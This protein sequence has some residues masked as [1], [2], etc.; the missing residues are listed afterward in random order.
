MAKTQR[1]RYRKDA[2]GGYLVDDLQPMVPRY[3]GQMQKTRNG[4]MI[5]PAGTT[6]RREVFLS[7]ES[8]AGVMLN[9]SKGN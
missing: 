2:A 9:E 1:F 7:R 3:I 6:R 5:A 4:W 8:S